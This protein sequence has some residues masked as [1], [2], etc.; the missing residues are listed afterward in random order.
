MFGD[1]TVGGSMA[2]QRYAYAANAAPFVW[3]KT[4]DRI[5]ATN[6][7]FCQRISDSGH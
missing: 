5:F 6:A 4:A 2:I 3:T 7:G 1:I